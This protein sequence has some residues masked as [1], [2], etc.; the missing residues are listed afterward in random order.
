MAQA[1]HVQNSPQNTYLDTQEFVQLKDG[2]FAWLNAATG[3]LTP[4]RRQPE[5]NKLF[6]LLEEHGPAE[7]EFMEGIDDPPIENEEIF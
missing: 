4:A 3:E 6:A 7:A 5:W 2:S 1:A